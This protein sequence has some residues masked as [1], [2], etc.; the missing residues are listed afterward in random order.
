VTA[1]FSIRR[2]RPADADA[3]AEVFILSRAAALPFLAKLHS[4]D[5]VR[6]WVSDILIPSADIWVGER[7]G[8]IVGFMAIGGTANETAVDHLYLHPD[9][10]RMGLGRSMIVLAKGRAP[11]GLRLVCFRDNH[12]AR[13][14]Y[15]SQ[16]F[17]LA[18]E[19]GPEANEEG[20]A[21]CVYVWT[22]SPR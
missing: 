20:A 9:V 2:A 21:D 12:A 22:P 16:G 14:F 17:V 13:R 10:R 18:E 8:R 19:R 1:G 15:E 3:V 6:R 5:A 11:A 4:D 7:D